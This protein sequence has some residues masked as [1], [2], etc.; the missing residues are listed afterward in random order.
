[1]LFSFHGPPPDLGA[2]VAPTRRSRR[3]MVSCRGGPRRDRP[4][5]VASKL[6]CLRLRAFPLP[7]LNNFSRSSLASRF[8]KS[9][10]NYHLRAGELDRPPPSLFSDTMLA[11]VLCIV[12]FFAFS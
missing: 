3:A 8:W 4:L 10:F 6:A 7:R 11:R 2:G 1:M 5:E 9:L 12:A